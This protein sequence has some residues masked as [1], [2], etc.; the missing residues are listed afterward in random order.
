MNQGEMGMIS[1]QQ[2]LECIERSVQLWI[3]MRVAMGEVEPE[4]QQAARTL[5]TLKAI[6]TDYR[7]KIDLAERNADLARQ[8]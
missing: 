6:A 3:V 8:R 7:D 1:D 5:T 4:G 2:K